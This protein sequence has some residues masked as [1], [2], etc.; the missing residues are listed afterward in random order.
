MEAINTEY[1]RDGLP[2]L[3]GHDHKKIVGRLRD[4]EVGADKVMRCKA[5]FGRSALAQEAR[6]N[7]E[8]G[9]LPTTSIGYRVDAWTE[10]HDASTDEYTYR[11]TRWTPMEGSLVAVPADPTVGVGRSAVAPAPASPAP[12]GVL[13]E[14]RMT[15]AAEPAPIVTGGQTEDQ[16]KI[17]ELTQSHAKL[18]PA[19]NARGIEALAT[20]KTFEQFSAETREYWAKRA[21]EQPASAAPIE[22]S[23]RERKQ[24][25]VARAI[26]HQAMVAEGRKVGGSFEFEVHQELEKKVPSN[27][28][29]HGGILVPM[30]TS[31]DTIDTVRAQVMQRA[32]LDA[33]NAT[34]GP[35]LKFTVP[36]EFLPILRNLLALQTM[37]ADYMPGLSSPVAFP[38][39]N[40]AGTA[41]W[42][43]ENGG[44]DV[45]DSNLLLQQ[46]ALTP[47]TIQSSTSYSRQLLAQASFDVDM[48]VKMDLAK[49]VALA[50]DLAGIAGTGASNQPTGILSTA[51]IGSVALGTNGAAVTFPNLV[52]LETQVTQVNADQWTLGYLTN[53]KQRGVMKKTTVLSN[54]IATPIWTAPGK[55]D[56]TDQNAG[57]NSRVIGE[58]NGYMALASMQT[59]STLTK[60]TSSGICSAI[61]FGAFSQLVMGD[62]GMFELIT[63]PYR[64]KKQGMIEVTAFSMVGVAI[65]YPGAFAAI[66]D[67]L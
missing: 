47:K 67:A 30:A 28:K 55:S 13:P 26:E 64:L 7:V 54:T 27:A 18:D 45:T 6:M 31:Q 65:K 46:I 10:E 36:G 32:G 24:Y 62:W 48:I 22:L 14:V 52:D 29:R 40:G 4:F 38:N 42:L 12:Q 33:T 51:G 15:T 1:M 61:I 50:W 8:D 41:Y 37:G 20:G 60:G 35:E 66:Q 39:Q 19:F 17:A 5:T 16:R 63:D 44:T 57:I 58:V 25:S 3:L 53:P 56:I 23:D 34:K 9:L 43:G 49:I 11:A 59:P 21:S 2:L